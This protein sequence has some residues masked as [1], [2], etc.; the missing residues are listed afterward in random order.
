MEFDG[1][2]LIFVQGEA[3]DPSAAGYNGR[4]YKR[5][6]DPEYDPEFDNEIDERPIPNFFFKRGGGDDA[7]SSNP[8]VP[9]AYTGPSAGPAP[10]DPL[11]TA[12]PDTADTKS[13]P[14]IDVN[15]SNRRPA[16]PKESKFAKVRVSQY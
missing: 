3:G 16:P 15:Y 4:A 14:S 13:E 1:L 11:R 9:P 6:F 5:A 2:V 10:A 7:A 12:N 8:S